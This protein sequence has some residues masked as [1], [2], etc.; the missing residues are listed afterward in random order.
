MTKQRGSEQ[1]TRAEPRP[2]APGAQRRQPRQS[3]S[4][5][6]YSSILQAAS[7]LFAE[8]GYERTTT[9]QIAAAAGISVGTL[10]RYFADKEAIF[11]ELY[12]REISQMRSR[13]LNGFS[14]GDL[15]GQDARGLVRKTMAL[16]FEVYSEQ[17]EL[18]R[19]LREQ[20]LKIPELAATRRSQEAEAHQA[21]QHI[22]TSAP[23]VRLPD[24]EIS[25]YVIT[26]FIES[27]IEDFV[28]HRRDV[29]DQQRVI[30][31]ATDF[32]LR[33][34]LIDQAVSH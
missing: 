31:A 16:A 25:S 10:Y 3:R 21:I 12:Q 8:Q 19:L 33:Y 2:S 9:H 23:G 26:V 30:D 27:L 4:V 15:I 6:T 13:L 28:L 22:L 11:K 29:F 1:V 32:I 20:S 24:V 18:R 14:L 17:P 7:G 5:E 34:A